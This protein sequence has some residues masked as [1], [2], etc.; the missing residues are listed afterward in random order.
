MQ[1]D[2]VGVDL[3]AD[4]ITLSCSADVS[5]RDQ[6]ESTLEVAVNEVE[7]WTMRN[8]LSLNE[9]KTKTI[10]ITG[11]RLQSRLPFKSLSV[12]TST[13]KELEQVDSVQLLGLEIDSSL[14]FVN[15]VDKMC[16]KTFQRLGVLNRV[17]QC[18]P[19]KCND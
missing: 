12:V 8:R 9:S 4:D 6:L 16:K 15:H 3:Y 2:S 18:L 1:L 10:L 7:R 17:K 13:G 19:L 11:K 14:S 5:D